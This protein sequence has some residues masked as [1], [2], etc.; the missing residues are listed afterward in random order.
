MTEYLY[1]DFARFEVVDEPNPIIE[2]IF[3]EA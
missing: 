3:K 2:E 1:T